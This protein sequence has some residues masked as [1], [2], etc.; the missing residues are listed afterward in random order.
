[1][2][3]S[4]TIIVKDVIHSK[5]AVTAKQGN[6]LRT[7]L[8]SA[9]KKHQHLRLDF[10]GINL[11]ITAFANTA[12]GALYEDF[13]TDYLNE[14]LKLDAKTL[15]AGQ[16]HNIQVSMANAKGKIGAAKINAITRQYQAQKAD[17]DAIRSDWEAVGRDMWQSL[18]EY[19]RNKSR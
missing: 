2:E 14:Y 11:L 4:T 13:D 5:L 18:G 7:V 3:S 17:Y 15:T 12:F 9:L 16:Q 6:Q 8:L 10:T 19:S 1:M